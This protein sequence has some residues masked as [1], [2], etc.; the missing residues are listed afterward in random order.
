MDARIDAL[1]ESNARI[2]GAL[3]ELPKRVDGIDARLTAGG[4]RDGATPVLSEA[5]RSRRFPGALNRAFP[6]GTRGRR[7]RIR[8][9]G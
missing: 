8:A 2:E 7:S 6:G 3:S 5:R 1:A 9:D 4:A